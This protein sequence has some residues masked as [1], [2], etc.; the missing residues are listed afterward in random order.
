MEHA[1]PPY[2]MPGGMPGGAADGH[3]TSDA[4][5]GADGYATSDAGSGADGYATSDA[6]SHSHGDA[7]SGSRGNAASADGDAAA[8]T[9]SISM[10]ARTSTVSCRSPAPPAPRR[11]EA[12]RQSAPECAPTPKFDEKAQNLEERLQAREAQIVALQ[13]D[14]EQLQKSLIR[15]AELTEGASWAAAPQLG[16]SQEGQQSTVESAQRPSAPVASPG[17]V[18]YRQPPRPLPD[19]TR[20]CPPVARTCG[21]RCHNAVC[22]DC[23]P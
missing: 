2:G 20:N 23:P 8:A 1:A 12:S 17:S 16:S 10:G 5:S 19:N 11:D 7:A 4:G 13:Q 3:A 6:A 9:A 14:I 21:N 15:I 22:G 18:E